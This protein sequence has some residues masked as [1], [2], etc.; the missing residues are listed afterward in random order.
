M[1]MQQNWLK[2]VEQLHPVP[3]E[4]GANPSSSPGRTALPDFEV[5]EDMKP[6]A[7]DSIEAFKL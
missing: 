3:E 5:G 2:T 4:P 6:V 7:K 1:T